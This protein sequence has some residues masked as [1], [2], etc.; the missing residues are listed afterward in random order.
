MRLRHSTSLVSGALAVVAL[1]ACGALMWTST[2]LRRINEATTANVD[3]VRLAEEAKINLLLFVREADPVVRQSLADN[4]QRRLARTAA[5]ATTH[6]MSAAAREAQA[7]VEALIS[8]G[9][10]GAANAYAAVDALVS[11]NSAQTRAA[12]ERAR[13]WD[14]TADAIGVATGLLLVLIVGGLLAWLQG[15]TVRPILAMSEAMSRFGEGDRDARASAGG[16]AEVREMAVRFN[17][18]A[19]AL[20]MQRRAQMTF[21]AGVA[22]DLKNPISVLKM[23][24]AVTHAPDVAPEVLRATLERVHRQIA[25]LERMVGDLL[26]VTNIEAGRLEM[27]LGVEDVA[28]LTQGAVELFEGTEA[29]HRIVL[30]L[31]AE[32]VWAYCDRLRVEQVVTNLVSNAIKYSSGDTAIRVSLSRAGHEAVLAVTDEGIGLEEADRRRLFEPFR[33]VGRSKDDVPGVG[34]GLFVVKRIVE[35]HHGHIDVASRPGCGSTFRVFLP[36]HAPV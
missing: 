14:R 32:P 15:A 30:E 27:R 34:L 28:R 29:R 3:A 2:E 33:R 5:E 36:E 10:G 31:P 13:A 9:D 22:H 17:E 16:P 6:E 11:V 26:D 1:T 18:M 19:S 23:S 21:L 8:G 4:V 35:A 24:V 7:K 12:L 25:R 20:A